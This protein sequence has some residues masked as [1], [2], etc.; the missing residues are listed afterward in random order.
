[1]NQD[2]FVSVA[3]V[4][5]NDADVVDVFV[6]EV[7]SALSQQFLHYE[8]V[9]I[10]NAS[11]DQTSFVVATLM[12]SVANVRSVRLA[13]RLNSETAVLAAIDTSIG[14]Y[15]ILM[16]P[17]TDPPSEVIAM[18]SIAKEGSDVVIGVQNSFDQNGVL[19]RL[20]GRPIDHWT[21]AVLGFDVPSGATG[22][23]VMSRYAVNSIARIRSKS[24]NLRYF[25]SFIGLRHKYVSYE[26]ICR[27]P[28][29]SRRPSVIKRARANIDAVFSNSAVPLRLV[30]QIGFIAAFVSL[31]SGV[32]VIA[33]A[34]FRRHV[35]EGWV[36]T[37][38]FS[39][40]MFFCLFLLLGVMSEYVVRILR[41]TREIPLYFVESESHS[42]RTDNTGADSDR[43]N[44]V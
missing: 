28:S 38:L 9:L 5:N 12:R 33:V 36:T 4:L 41:E 42:L 43:L 39:S 25:V 32:Y 2:L 27:R 21:K 1:M 20:I 14:D 29:A 44:V 37:N 34:L 40:T 26:P 24:R 3:A 16:D 23:M 18:L 7:S 15:L 10:D 6:R 11:E 13:R 22:F 31:I 35:V 30:S 8:I 17:V 19:E